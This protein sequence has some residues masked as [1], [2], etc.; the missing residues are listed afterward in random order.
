M[1]LSEVQFIVVAP[2]GEKKTSSSSSS[3]LKT[4]YFSNSSHPA[5][6]PRTVYLCL[7][8]FLTAWAV[9][10]A[11]GSRKLRKTFVVF[12]CVLVV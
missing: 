12:S 8:S 1:S 2:R 3:S 10:E 4:T 7:G 5:R 6:G 11:P 9:P